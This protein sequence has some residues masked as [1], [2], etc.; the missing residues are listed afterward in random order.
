MENN[1]FD[2]IGIQRHRINTDGTGI[3]TLIGLKGCPLS[4]KYCINK[5]VLTLKKPKSYSYE[6]LFTEVMQDYCYFIATKG[7]ITF[8]GG[9]PLLH[10]NQIA[11]FRK[12]L[13][14]DIAINIETSLNIDSGIIEYI[15]SSITEW[16]ID[17]KDLDSNLYKR[18]TGK[19]VRKVI[20]NLELISKLG[21]QNKCL[22][23]VPL[24]LNFNTDRDRDNSIEKLNKLGF[25]RINRFRYIEIH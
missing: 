23:R 20:E 17:I 24:I 5:D 25:H 11:E 21:L 18:Y 7:G 8:G 10:Y 15:K 9:E 13:P 22:I 2:V 19:D 4:C 16:I 14:L 3:T 12:I 6:E 1:K